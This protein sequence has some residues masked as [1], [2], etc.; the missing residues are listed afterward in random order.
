MSIQIRLP[1]HNNYAVTWNR[2]KIHDLYPDSLLDSLLQSTD[3]DM[4]E[5]LQ[6]EITP[7]ILDILSTHKLPLSF[8]SPNELTMAYRYLGIPFLLALTDNGLS[9]YIETYRQRNWN[10]RVLEAKGRSRLRTLLINKMDRLFAYV[11]TYVP[12]NPEDDLEDLTTAMMATSP[13]AVK[14]LIARLPQDYK[15]S[16][17]Q[18]AKL[19]TLACN[20]NYPDVVQFVLPYLELTNW[21][22][23]CVF[24]FALIYKHSILL[25]EFMLS[26]LSA[27]YV[28]SI[29][30]FCQRNLIDVTSLS[31]GDFIMMPE[32]E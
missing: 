32:V 18:T 21:N 23:R 3:A 11:L 12:L 1:N 10:P 6:P 25:K 4:V 29:G 16:E 22:A 26:G 7:A 14:L 31:S 2:E 8:P 20:N 5:I 17:T 24:E 27:V 28:D 13:S 9:D 19:R 15:V 30:R